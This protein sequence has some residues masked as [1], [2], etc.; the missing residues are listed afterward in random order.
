MPE[1]LLVL[2]HMRQHQLIALST[3]E[4]PVIYLAGV[5]LS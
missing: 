1:I 4:T 2:A 3:G 5:R